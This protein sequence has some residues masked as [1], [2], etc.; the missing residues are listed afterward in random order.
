[1]L[2]LTFIVA[3]IALANCKFLK[4]FDELLNILPILK[5]RAHLSKQSNEDFPAQFDS[6]TKYEQCLALNTIQDQGNCGSCWSFSS[7]GA[8]ADAMC[9]ANMS[10]FIP[11]I[12]RQICCDT[13]CLD[14]I[15][16]QCNYGCNGGMLTKAGL[17]IETDGLVEEQCIPYKSE[18]EDKCY[19]T[20]I[21][22]TPNE[23]EYQQIDFN[24]EV[25]YIVHKGLYAYVQILDITEED[26]MRGIMSSGSVAVSMMV[27]DNFQEYTDGIYTEISG[28]LLGGHGVKLI[29]WG[30][31]DNIP[32]WI[33]QNSW[34][35]SW[36]MD[37]YCKYLRGYDLGNIESQLIYFRNIPPPSS[38]LSVQGQFAIYMLSFFAV[39]M[40]SSFL[41]FFVAKRYYS[42]KQKRENALSIERVKEKRLK[43]NRIIQ[44]A[45]QGINSGVMQQQTVGSGVVYRNIGQGSEF[46]SN[47][48][49]S[50]DS[51]SS[52][53][54]RLMI[55]IQSSTL[56]Q[57]FSISPANSNLLMITPDSQHNQQAAS[58]LTNNNQSG[59]AF[60]TTFFDS[61]DNDTSQKKNISGKQR[62]QN[63]EEK[64]LIGNEDDDEED[65]RAEAILGRHAKKKHGGK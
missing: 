61:L 55:P 23:T 46:Q 64:G 44:P 25:K 52:E 1:M 41:I 48:R 12:Q 56:Q 59:S 17:F 42:G 54:D 57:P 11:S 20:C 65:D 5:P 19:K 2:L 15:L 4:S 22:Q 49:S 43:N 34:G 37:G 27:Y 29:G 53:R 45:Q 7:A 33:L 14:L 32:Y 63:E 13:G 30:V 9:V 60:S 62:V 36:G 18:S 28:S 31:E 39:A 6:R 40:I 16:P 50:I 47:V 26:I 38:G 35:K 10:I 24:E 51:N 58:S 3:S 21:S 8:A